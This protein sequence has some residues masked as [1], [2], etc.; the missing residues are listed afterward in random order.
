MVQEKDLRVLHLDPKAGRRKL[1]IFYTGWSL[2]IGGDLKANP[3]S[4]TLPP[5][6]PHLLIVLLSMGQAYSNHHT[7]FL[8]HI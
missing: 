8:S 1:T 4:H 5:T 3:H 2:S 6:K 7:P